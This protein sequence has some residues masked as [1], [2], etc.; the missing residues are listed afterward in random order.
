MSHNRQIMFESIFF[1]RGS[2]LEDFLY[3]CKKCNGGVWGASAYRALK[4]PVLREVAEVKHLVS[5]STSR[6]GHKTKKQPRLWLSGGMVDP[7][8]SESAARKGMSVRVRPELL[9]MY[10]SMVDYLQLYGKRQRRRGL[11]SHAY[12]ASLMENSVVTEVRHLPLAQN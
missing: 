5:V 11:K 7:A 9:P 8:E 1:P 2:N 10:R 4:I 6:I 12:R 3:I